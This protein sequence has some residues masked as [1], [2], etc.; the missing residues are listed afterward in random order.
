MQRSPFL[1]KA[2]QQRRMKVAVMA[3]FFP[4]CHCPEGK[5]HQPEM[6]SCQQGQGKGEPR[7]LI[8]LPYKFMA[9]LKDVLHQ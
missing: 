9:G 3:I 1:K 6:A 7:K 8:Q 4:Q 2:F 5:S